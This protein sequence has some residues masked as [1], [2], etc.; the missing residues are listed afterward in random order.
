MQHIN[1]VMPQYTAQL[2][3]VPYSSSSKSTARAFGRCKLLIYVLRP[4]TVAL[5]RNGEAAP[6]LSKTLLQERRSFPILSSSS[7]SIARR[8]LVQY[9]KTAT[10]SR[11]LGA[12][13][14]FCQP[15]LDAPRFAASLATQKGTCHQRLLLDEGAICIIALVRMVWS[16]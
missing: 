3:A 1:T 11:F 4:G 16:G 7:L 6:L 12:V 13:V 15:Q 9:I 5:V 10:A 8:R 2:F 14:G